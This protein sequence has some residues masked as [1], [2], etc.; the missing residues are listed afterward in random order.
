MS[1][2]ARQ[3]QQ[4]LALQKARLRRQQMRDALHDSAQA[5]LHENPSLQAV[6]DEYDAAFTERLTQKN[7]QQRALHTFKQSLEAAGL[8]PE[9]IAFDMQLIAV[10]L[11]RMKNNRV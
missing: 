4:I 11:R 9:D 6:V 2:V 8:P 3:D 7:Q 10:E 5:N 1:D